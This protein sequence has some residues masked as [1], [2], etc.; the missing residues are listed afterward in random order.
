MDA[1][2]FALAPVAFLP[3]DR[4][5][6]LCSLVRRLSKPPSVQPL[7]SHQCNDTADPMNAP[8]CKVEHGSTVYFSH[9]Y[10]HALHEYH[11]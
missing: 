3:D 5:M 1:S 2:G 4:H 9:S 10:R 6:P 7:A 8:L 11:T